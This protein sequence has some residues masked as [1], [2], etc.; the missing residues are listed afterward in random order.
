MG[1]YLSIMSGVFSGAEARMG[2]FARN[3]VAR[4]ESFPLEELIALVKREYGIKSLDDLLR[5]HL[6][7]ALNIAHGGITIDGNPDDLQRDHIFPKSL[8]EKLGYPYEIINHYA[9]FHF[10]RGVD[11]LNKLDKPPH[12]WFMNPGKNVP[13]YSDKDLEERLLSW[14]DLQPGNFEVMIERRGKRI[15]EKAEQLFGLSEQEFNVLFADKPTKGLDAPETIHGGEQDTA[16]NRAEPSKLAAL[17]DSENWPCAT[18]KPGE[19]ILAAKRYPKGETTAWVKIEQV[20]NVCILGILLEPFPH[21]GRWKKGDEVWVYGEDFR[22]Y[23]KTPPTLP[24]HE[25]P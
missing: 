6:D 25:T 13:S 17:K 8:L 7:L 18:L 3:K 21:I 2:A 19:Y 22:A 1:I 15:R 24:P 4:A 12:E 14:D 11:N 5:R 10:L 20:K 23:S 9:N 16:E